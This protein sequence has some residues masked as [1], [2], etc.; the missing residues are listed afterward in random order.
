MKKVFLVTV[1]LLMYINSQAQTSQGSILVGAGIGFNS[2]NNKNKDGDFTS[3][4]ST[5]N[6][7]VGGG[8]F[9]D[10]KLALGIDLNFGSSS[11]SSNQDANPDLEKT[12]STTF[13]ISPFARYYYMLDDKFGFFG[14][15][16]IPI[17]SSQNKFEGDKQGSS[18]GAGLELK[19][20]MVFFPNSKFGI[21]SSIGLLGLVNTT[22]KD[23]DGNKTSSNSTFNLGASSA[24]QL[25]NLGFRYYI[26]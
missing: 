13:G 12:T 14:Q 3:K 2:S 16:A 7:F 20:G 19:P 4:S 11:N 9:L 21:E 8:Y 18:I 23:K 1:A 5:S 6:L 25:F 26:F 22:N 24:T 17:S 15:L 10:D